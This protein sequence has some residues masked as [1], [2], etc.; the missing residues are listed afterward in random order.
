M[1]FFVYLFRKVFHARLSFVIFARITGESSVL[2][3]F[4][5]TITNKNFHSLYLITP[6][7]LQKPMWAL[8]LTLILMCQTRNYGPR[9]WNWSR[10]YSLV[11]WD[12]LIHP[13]A[14]INT[15]IRLWES[16]V[17]FPCNFIVNFTDS[18]KGPTWLSLYSIL[19][20]V[21]IHYRADYQV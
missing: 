15:I 4:P 19:L 13:V 1:K 5:T 11:E 16:G 21:L 3:L 17:P 14:L 12:W 7:W 18:F 10:Q 6:Q 9:E 2:T 8:I 20:E